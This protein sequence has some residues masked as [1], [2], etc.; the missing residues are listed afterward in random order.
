MSKLYTVDIT[1]TYHAFLTVHVYASSEADAEA[2][3]QQ[4]IEQGLLTFGDPV[5]LD[6]C[7]YI[8]A[9]E[10]HEKED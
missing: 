10:C 3:A 4:L 8:D 1:R 2:Q 6:D 7:D 5:C 9:T